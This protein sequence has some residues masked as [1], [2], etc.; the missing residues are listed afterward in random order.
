M[1][2]ER[3]NSKQNRICSARIAWKVRCQIWSFFFAAKMS[4]HKPFLAEISNINIFHI[5]QHF[6]VKSYKGNQWNLLTF[7]NIFRVYRRGFRISARGGRQ[8]ID[9]LIWDGDE[10]FLTYANTNL[11]LF[12]TFI[13]ILSLNGVEQ[14]FK[15]HQWPFFL[16]LRRRNPRLRGCPSVPGVGARPSAPPPPPLKKTHTQ[17]LNKWAFRYYRNLSERQIL[18]LILIYSMH[19]DFCSNKK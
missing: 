12:K 2:V 8:G 7:W 19:F 5:I 15:R 6:W 18:K 11:Q 4:S 13:A 1:F 10:R 9:D 16:P 3:L 17:N 14:S